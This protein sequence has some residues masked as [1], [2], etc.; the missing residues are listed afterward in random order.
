MTS[1]EQPVRAPTGLPYGE[2]QKLEQAQQAIPLP[3]QPSPQGGGQQQGEQ[4][5]E[6]PDVFAPTGRP[7]EPLT[8][9]AASGPGPQS[10]ELLPPDPVAH[11]RALYQ[12]FPHEDLRRLLE[13][14]SESS[15]RGASGRGGAESP[16]PSQPTGPVAQPPQSGSPTPPEPR[17]SPP[18]TPPSPR[19]V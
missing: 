16:T 14:A 19:P 8:A 9:G 5:V 17:S 18:S 4:P 15:G 6:R 11:L 2:K 7:S 1:R 10:L 13:R 3:A 12:R